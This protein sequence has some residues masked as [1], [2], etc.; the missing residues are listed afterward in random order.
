V[1][2]AGL[3]TELDDPG[4][5][6]TL[7]HLLELMRNGGGEWCGRRVSGGRVVCVDALAMDRLRA[8]FHEVGNTFTRR[9]QFSLSAPAHIDAT[10]WLG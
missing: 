5:L 8:T 7:P 9:S 10:T 6:A 2:P 4:M 1:L 3:V